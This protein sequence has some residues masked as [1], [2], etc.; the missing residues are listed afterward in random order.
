[1]LSHGFLSNIIQK[2][3]LEI[4]N[5]DLKKF[6][7]ENK[8]TTTYFSEI[9]KTI[10]SVS[11]LINQKILSKVKKLLKNDKPLICNVELHLQP[12]NSPTIPVHQD[13]FYHCINH[14]EGLKILIP[15]QPMDQNSGSLIFMDCDLNFPIQKHISS[16]VRNFSSYIPEQIS[17]NLKLK[18]TSY[19]YRLGD[20][21]YHFINS[22]H[23]SKGNISKNQ[24]FFIVFRFQIPNATIDMKALENYEKCLSDHK[25]LIEKNF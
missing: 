10:P 16:N 14:N 20:A 17:K 22:I 11:D 4:V 24:I 1:M 25:K 2:R 19:T 23:F 15:L 13:N 12:K 7:Y 9:H 21:S 18:E 5:L 3:D 8:I 6:L